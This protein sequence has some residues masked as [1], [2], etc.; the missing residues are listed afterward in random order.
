M[1]KSLVLGCAIAM[2]AACGG[3]ESD[4]LGV[5]A[6]CG[7]TD[8]CNP[9][10]ATTCLTQFKGGYCGVT[11]CQADADCPESSACVV[12]TDGMNYCFRICTDKPECNA[13]RDVDNEANCSGSVDFVDPARTSKAC[14]PPSN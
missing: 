1:I 10:I 13:N 2:A 9:D 12:H 3:N 8:D 11:G 6:Q 7:T 4:E 5:G 14:I